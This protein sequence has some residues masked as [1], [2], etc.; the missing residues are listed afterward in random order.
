[1]SL[2]IKNE[3]THALVRELAQRTGQSQT[4]AVESAVRAR[5]EALEA[6]DREADSQ[7]DREIDAIIARL[8][9]LPDIGPTYEEIVEDMYDEDGLPR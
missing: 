5:L 2:N 7:R 4:G 1:M 9:A 6:E 8:Q 3:R